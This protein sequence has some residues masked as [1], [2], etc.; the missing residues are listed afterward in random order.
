MPLPGAPNAF[1]FIGVKLAAI[2]RPAETLLLAE[3]PSSSG[4]PS[5]DP[6]YVNNVF[7]AYSGSYVQN[8]SGT[9]GQDT[10][11]PGKPIHLEGWNYLFSDGHVKWLRPEQ[12]RVGVTGNLAQR[13]PGNLW[14]RIKE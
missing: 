7:G 13:V 2:P 6:T 1:V 3:R 11:K 12:T 9:N 10:A 14:A 8:T 4:V 5:S